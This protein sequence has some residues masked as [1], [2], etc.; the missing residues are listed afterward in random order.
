MW[1]LLLYLCFSLLL[2]V[3]YLSDSILLIS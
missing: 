3:S 1:L 2:K